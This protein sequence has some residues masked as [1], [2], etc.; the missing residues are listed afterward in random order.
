MQTR[1][2]FNAIAYYLK[3]PDT[4][5]YLREHLEKN[6]EQHEAFLEEYEA[7]DE[8]HRDIIEWFMTLP[9]WLDIE[10]IRV[11]HACW[12]RELISRTM[13]ELDGNA[14]LNESFMIRASKKDCWEYEAI[15][16]LLKGKEIPMKNGFSYKDVKGV[17]RHN[18]R[19]RW[20]D[21][22]AT[23]Y[24]SAYM[25]PESARTH[26]PDD[27][28]EGDHLVEYGHDEPPVFLGHYWLEGEPKPL[29]KNIACLDYSVAKAGGKLV[30]YR[31]DGE[32]EIIKDK[33][34]GVDSQVKMVF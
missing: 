13:T 11:I 7:D 32:A 31:W 26:I 27:E 6:R 24:K 19:V 9:L 34:I 29:A 3:D 8:A 25:G 15:E 4:G 30:A 10:D 2:E 22:D 12:D 16:T 18:M 28:I 21:K 33:Y 14:I 1:H 23:T 20:W 5:E 17:P